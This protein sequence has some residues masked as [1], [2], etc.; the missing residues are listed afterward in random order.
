[1]GCEPTVFVV[2]DD[3]AMRAGL[4]VLVESV[5]L[6]TQ[7]YASAQEFLDS[8]DPD[9][10]GCLVLDVRMP[11]MS[12]IELQKKLQANGMTV[13]VILLTGHGDI[14]MAVEALQDGALD[15]IEKPCRPQ[16]LL[17][18]IQ[19][20]LAKDAEAHRAKVQRDSIAARFALLTPRER[21][22]VDLAVTG[23]TNKQIAARFS[24]SPQAID[25]QR[26]RAMAKLEAETV[27]DLVRLT[28]KRESPGSLE[29]HEWG[30]A[31]CG[32]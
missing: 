2:D 32:Y 28:L 5:G 7:D 18:R 17:D 4:R 25:A 24:V 26:A 12:G 11:G 19:Q 29:R 16:L 6:R 21:A 8:Y 23:M 15:F 13:P 30:C 3:P 10:R 22:V 1:M 14:P 31:S 9:L 20:A 27:V